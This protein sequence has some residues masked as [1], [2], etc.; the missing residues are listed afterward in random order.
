MVTHSAMANFTF[1]LPPDLK[2]KLEALRASLG[3]RSHAETARALIA[4][5]HE[6][7]GVAVTYDPVN[8]GLKERA[9]Q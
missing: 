5:R 3:L 1:D 2:A 7:L 6:R 8:G 4:D 9:P